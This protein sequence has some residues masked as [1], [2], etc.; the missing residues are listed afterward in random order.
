MAGLVNNLGGTAGFGENTLGRDDDGS[1]GFIDLTGIFG[2]EGLNFYGTNYTGLFV[3]NNGSVTFGSASG[4]AQSGAF[5]RIASPPR[6]AAFWADVDT[7]SGAV[8]P[9]PTGTSTGSNLVYWD[10]DVTNGTFTAIWDDVG[11][12]NQQTDKLNAFQLS[13]TR[14]GPAGDF[15]ITFNYE[16]INW[17]SGSLTTSTPARVGFT[18]GNTVNFVELPQSGNPAA[19]LDIESGTNGNSPG[20]YT[21]NVRGGAV[22]PVLSFENSVINIVEGNSGSRFVT[23]PVTL[24][25][26]SATPVT[27]TYTT[28]SSSALAGEDFTAQTGTLT[29]APGVTRQ[30][31][32]IEI[33]G[34]TAVEDAAIDSD[35]VFKVEL[36]NASGAQAPGGALIVNI[37]NDDGFKV[38]ADVEV[39]EG[40]GPGTTTATV[41][42]SLLS[43]LASTATVDYATELGFT[44]DS[45]D[46]TATSGTLTFNP[47]DTSKTVSVPITRDGDVEPRE[48]FVLRLSNPTGT[49]IADLFPVSAAILNDDGIVID[50]ITVSEGAGVANVTVR[51]L[52]PRAT[53]T[54]F[55]VSPGDVSARNISD[56]ELRTSESG[57]IPAGQTSVTVPVR[58]L[59]DTAV[60]GTET[61]RVF[62]STADVGIA[63]DRATVTILDDDRKSVSITDAALAEGNAGTSTMQ[64]TVTLAQA[65]TTVTTIPFSTVAGTASASSDYV[66][67]SGSLTFNAGETSKTITVVINGDLSAEP[68]ESFT[69]TLNPTDT[70]ITLLRGTGTGTIFNDDG[71]SIASATV[72]EGNAGTQVVNVTVTLSAAS[73]TPVTVQYATQDGTATA[74]V[75]Y[76]ARSGALTFAAGETSKTIA[77]TVNGDTAFEGD[78]TFRVL[79]SSPTGSAIADGSATVTITNDDTRPPPSLR[80][81]DAAIVEGTGAGS[82][83]MRFQVAL[84]EVRTAATTVDFGTG[85]NTASANIDFSP[86]VGTLTIPAGSLVGYVDV[87]VTRDASVESNEAFTL[88][89]SNPSS[90]VTIATASAT[91]TILTDDARIAI[92]ATASNK[93]EGNSGSTPF[94]FTLQRTGDTS[95]THSASWTVSGTE[96]NGADFTGGALPSGTVT[97]APG[98]TFKD[99]TVNV[100]G[101]GQA[102]GDERFLFTLSNPSTGAALGTATTQGTIFNE[103]TQIAFASGTVSTRQGSGAGGTV[104]L[105]LNRA[106]LLTDAAQVSWAVT[107]GTAGAADFA[108]GALPSGTASFAVGATTANISFQL[109][110]DTIN[111]SNE[112]YTVTL[113]NPTGGATL[114]TATAAGTITDD[115][116]LLYVAPTSADKAEGNSGATAYT[117]TVTRTGFTGDKV[118]ADWA[119]TGGTATGADFAGGTLPSGTVALLAGETTKTITVNVAGDTLIEPDETFT[120]SLSNA[121]PAGAAIFT[122]N[123]QG[124]IRTDDTQIAIQTQRVIVAEG[125]SG[126]TP[127]SFTLTRTGKTDV[128]HTVSYS[129]DPSTSTANAADFAGGTAPSGS[130][131]FAAGETT[132]TLTLNV[133]GDTAKESNE[134]TSILLTAGSGFALGNSTGSLLILNDDSNSAPV[135]AGLSPAITRSTHVQPLSTL[136]GL[137]D[138]GDDPSANGSRAGATLWQVWDITAG[139]GRVQVNGIDQAEV[140]QINLTAAEFQNA[141][142]RAGT[143]TDSLWA[144]AFDGTDWTAWTNTLVTGPPNQIP[145]VSAPNAFLTVTNATPT[146]QSL[147]KMS[148]GDNDAAQRWQFWD[149]TPGMG[150]V[151]VGGVDRGEQTLIDLTAAEFANGNFRTTIGWD[152]LWV[153]AF[154][155]YDWSAWTNLF[156]V[157]PPNTPP[158]LTIANIQTTRSAPLAILSNALSFSD[159]D[160]DQ[161]VNY[162]FWD[163]TVDGGGLFAKGTLQPDSTLITLTAA[164][165]STAQVSGSAAGDSMWMRASDGKEWSAWT[166]FA[167]TGQAGNT[168]PMLTPNQT[169]F[170]GA[171]VTRS[172]FSIYTP[173][174]ADSDPFRFFQLWDHT[175]GNGS[176]TVGG[177]AQAARTL[178]NLSAIQAQTA[179]FTSG[180]GD[181]DVWA[182]AWDGFEWGAWTYARLDNLV[183]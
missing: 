9:T 167:V 23:I 99:V 182:R 150:Q 180:A 25:A 170:S 127:A 78:E 54:N 32:S 64:F 79:L 35:E 5:S 71:L 72:T 113:S 40:T 178:I 10:I 138:P 165:A 81:V 162:Q 21:F 126:T 12:Y 14:V 171:G 115:E 69:V 149:A 128:A 123:A 111:E 124:T 130:I 93:P 141:V 26:P 16:A 46:F 13:L 163:A 155:G 147:M 29:F 175:P 73:A 144:R 89:L 30:S 88:N 80:V 48:T 95:V 133:A 42:V 106:G 158:V 92:V 160:G 7:R 97:F 52:A 76:V 105:Q 27:V 74:G 172:L 43:P 151:T 62:I 154:D 181:D 183:V 108:G 17:T 166:N 159:A 176:F 2:V 157:A 101:D 53:N 134:N 116:S 119:V 56:Y 168:A 22:E 122:A 59:N 75:D 61:F 19:L 102:E 47:G 15:D 173:F 41:T 96:V 86:T 90:G 179:T 98:D 51:L 148:D 58:I 37:V 70:A 82:T 129:T 77:V 120:V 57:V 55:T 3:N 131:T 45:A 121:L 84:S 137:T 24:S 83:F 87:P 103:D 49:G 66:A 177:V 68:A 20:V 65:A 38:S 94:T 33:L 169:T 50:D 143:G 114:G 161:P 6:I 8:T 136:F 104:T 145:V 100:A 91:G 85:S 1:S 28:V 125:N 152:Q 140:A 36:S 67:Q 4:A 44:T 117:F 156:I 135:L 146:L 109:A 18:S 63:D 39:T 174:D 132:K 139:A 107:P 34:D 112:T 31:I 164:E 60:E 110:G 11:Y 153:R 118:T 142:F